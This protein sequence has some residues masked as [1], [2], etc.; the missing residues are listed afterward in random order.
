[1]ALEFEGLSRRYG[2]VIALDDLSFTV[3]AGEVV[4]FLGPNGS[5]KTTTM[6]AVFG[7]VALD[8]APAHDAGRQVGAR[9]SSRS[10]V[11]P[12]TRTRADAATQLAGPAGDQTSADQAQERADERLLLRRC[13]ARHGSQK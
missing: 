10:S 9:G 2:D 5:G 6:R 1:V 13:L 3:P 12:K 4:G 7:L 11:S 8:P